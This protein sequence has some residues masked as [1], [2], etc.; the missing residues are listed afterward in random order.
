MTEYFLTLQLDA[1]HTMDI[2]T[3]A[4]CAYD[5]RMKYMQSGGK[6]RVIAVRPCIKTTETDEVLPN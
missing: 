3:E 4:P 5:A 1:Q 6:Y 2:R